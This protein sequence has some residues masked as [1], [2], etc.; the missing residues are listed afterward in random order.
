MHN[1][2][3]HETWLEPR[4]PETPVQDSDHRN[5]SVLGDKCEPPPP[6]YIRGPPDVHGDVH[7]MDA[8]LNFGPLL[9]S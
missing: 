5:S 6:D 3:K 8:K 7:P 2:L 9:P 1:A 4:R